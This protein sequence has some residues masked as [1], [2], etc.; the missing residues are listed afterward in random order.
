MEWL[1]VGYLLVGTVL[2]VVAIVVGFS[3][4]YLRF[5]SGDLFAIAAL[6]AVVVL[7]WLP[8]A[9]AYAVRWLIGGMVR[10]KCSR[11]SF[12]ASSTRKSITT[13][14]RSIGAFLR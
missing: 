1:L 11:C 10:L 8:I 2:S 14:N 7:V 13:S 4:G 9:A 5:R 12:S 3:A 6:A